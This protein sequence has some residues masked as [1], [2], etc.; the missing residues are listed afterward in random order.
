MKTAVPDNF[1]NTLMKA[2]EILKQD[3]NKLGY[4]NK[5]IIAINASGFVLNGSFDSEYYKANSA[6]NKTSVSPIV[7][8]NGKTLR[9]FSSKTIPREKHITYGLKKDGYLDY[10]TYVKG[11][12]VE[13]NIAT[14]KKIINDG[15]KYTFAFNPVLVENKKIVATKTDRNIRQGFCQI[16]KNNFV[17]ITN[18]SG[19]RSIG[20][21][22]KS[23]AEY[24][25]SL[26]C[27]TGFNLDGG[28]ST[29]LLFKEN[30]DISVL[31]GNIRNIADILYFHE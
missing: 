15:V 28:G 23:L 27:E 4:Q 12:N 19:N 22:F 29:T 2:D 7:I 25:I 11:T 5:T 6:W 21:S 24:M 9:D 14:S 31:Y 3:I 18:N 13:A 16:D 8:V 26:N 17:F 30:N 10:Y 20:F 1:G